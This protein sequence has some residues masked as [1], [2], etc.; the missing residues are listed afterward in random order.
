MATSNV[1]VRQN[2]WF[3][4]AGFQKYSDSIKK[5]VRVAYT[6]AIKDTNI[7]TK[8]EMKSKASSYFKVSKKT[9]LNTFSSKIYDTKPN[10]LPSI[11]FRNKINWFPLHEFGGVING[12]M[13]I[14]FQ[15]TNGKKVDAKRW[16]AL[17]KTLKQNKQSFWK[18]INGKVILFALINKSNS[19]LMSGYRQSFKARN[20]V[21]RVTAGTAIPIGMMVDKIR[22]KRRYPFHDIVTNFAP[23]KIISNFNANLDLS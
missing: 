15:N 16:K 6:K 5:K 2:A 12:K 9:F 22:L 1:R 7:E 14:P 21:K 19:R 10:K 17:L 3:T 13:V 18:N 11:L 23:K 20:N 4:P 8:K